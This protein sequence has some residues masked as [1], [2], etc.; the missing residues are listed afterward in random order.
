LEFREVY[1]HHT[2]EWTHTERLRARF[3]VEIPI[4][5]RERAWK[6]KTLYFIGNV[7]PMY[8]FDRND[9]DPS[10]AQVGIGYVLNARIRPELLYYANWGRSAEGAPLE[11]N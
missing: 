9:I 7:E 5:S 1:H 8:R 11:F 4:T 3:G 2:H 10:R 6:E